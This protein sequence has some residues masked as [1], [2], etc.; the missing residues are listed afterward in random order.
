[1]WEKQMPGRVRLFHA[2]LSDDDKKSGV[3]AL[4]NSEA[5]LLVATTVVEVGISIPSLRYVLVVKP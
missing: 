1:M 4:K 3:D 2:N 5:D